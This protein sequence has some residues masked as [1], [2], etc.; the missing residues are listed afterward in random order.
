MKKITTIVAIS[1]LGLIGPSLSLAAN[2][3]SIS[4]A[5]GT[6]VEGAT[7]V[8]SIFVDPLGG[9]IYT[10]K[11]ELDFPADL[12]RVNSFTMNSS[13]TALNQ[14]GYDLIDNVNG[15]LI[16]SGGFASGLSSKVLFG[17]VS[18]T[19]KKA[20]SAT[21]KINSNSVVIDGNYN[22]ILTV[23]PSATYVI[24]AKAVPAPTPKPIPPPAL[25]NEN[26]ESTSE[27]AEIVDEGTDVTEII[28]D[29][30]TP[31]V[32]EENTNPPPQSLL[33]NLAGFY[34]ASES[35][36]AV[37]LS[38]IAVILIIGF[39]VAGWRI[40]KSRMWLSVV[41]FILVALLVIGIGI[42]IALN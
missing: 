5:S 35:T 24:S 6:Y 37:I 17:T 10:A 1:I 32:V 38:I 15:K 28:L 27:P 11:A 23:Y 20:G 34:S 2:N 19:S 31:E 8:V 25:S 13:W 18:F 4:P 41:L 22:N 16:K 33:A 3:I 14:P 40:R 36:M 21:I 7:Y 29:N 26:E 30:P 9:K 39:G 42:V 12:L